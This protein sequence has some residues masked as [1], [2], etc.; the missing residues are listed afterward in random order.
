MLFA[1]LEKTP[2]LLR[3]LSIPLNSWGFSLRSFG[4]VFLKSSSSSPQILTPLWTWFDPQIIEFSKVR[5][6]EKLCSARAGVFAI[7]G[8]T[9]ACVLLRRINRCVDFTELGFLAVL[10][11]CTGAWILHASVQPVKP[12]LLLFCSFNRRIDF[13][14][15]R[16]NRCSGWS[17]LQTL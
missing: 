11:R 1:F 2:L 17:V 16:F 8:W 6:L 4:D 7:V 15:R 14:R 10:L 12:F 3:F 5:G 9:D 13:S